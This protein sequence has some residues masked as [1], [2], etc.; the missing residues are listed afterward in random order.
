M[1]RLCIELQSDRGGDAVTG[2]KHWAGFALQDPGLLAVM[3]CVLCITYMHS[4]HVPPGFLVH[5]M[6]L[7]PSDAYGVISRGIL[8]GP[9]FD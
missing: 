2:P 6:R 1:T 5:P 7:H 9:P 3:G 8:E 4:L